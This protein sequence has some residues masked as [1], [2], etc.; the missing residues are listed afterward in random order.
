MSNVQLIKQFTHAKQAASTRD[1]YN[2]V[3]RRF[4]AYAQANSYSLQELLSSQVDKVDTLLQQYLL[5]Q[6]LSQSSLHVHESA[7]FSFFAYY[8]CAIQHNK[9]R[10]YKSNRAAFAHP[11]TVDKQLLSP[12]VPLRTKCILALLTF[13]GLSVNHIIRL[14]ANYK[15]SGM[16]L[17]SARFHINNYI[18][19]SNHAHNAL[20]AC[21]RDGS[22]N[23]SRQ[24]LW[25][26]LKAIDLTPIAV[27][28]SY[29]YRLYTLQMTDMEIVETSNW[30]HDRVYRATR[31]FRR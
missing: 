26:S 14:K 13:Q 21:D 17:D 5:A 31:S 9:I 4:A 12:N 28:T 1:T 11:D 3:L 2:G 15:C 24:I 23:V 30:N 7:V 8:K 10:H 27:Q 25:K 20:I 16:F 22:S 19:A 29:I 6:S 18:N